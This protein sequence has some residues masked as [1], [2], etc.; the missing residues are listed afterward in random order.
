MN[1][2]KMQN[3]EF[4]FLKRCPEICKS[5]EKFFNS[6]KTIIWSG[7]LGLFEKKPYDKSTNSL[8]KL[9]NSFAFSPSSQTN[10][11]FPVAFLK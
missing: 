4:I 10:F 9:I 7:P 11:I 1:Y 3:W 5:S 6:S 8:V 2:P